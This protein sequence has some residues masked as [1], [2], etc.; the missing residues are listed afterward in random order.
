[1]AA[2]GFYRYQ[3]REEVGRVFGFFE[4][5]ATGG[6]T[7]TIVDTSLTR[8]ADDYFIG[9]SVYILYAGG[10]TPALEESYCTDFVSST[11]TITV[12][13]AFTAAV[14]SGDTYQLY[15]NV[16]VDEINYCLNAV[17][18]D[19]EIETQLTPSASTLDYYVSGAKDLYRRQQ[20]I[21]VWVRP[22]A[23]SLIMPYELTGWKFFDNEGELYVRIPY[24][25]SSTDQLWLHY[26]GGDL[27][28][29]DCVITN[30][31]LRLIR[32]RATVYL[33]ENLIAHQNQGGMDRWGTLLRYWHEELR[34][35]EARHQRVH[36][37]VR[38]FNWSGG[39]PEAPSYDTVGDARLNIDSLYGDL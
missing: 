3:L 32:A 15:K 14:E 39:F 35:E 28:R 21:G 2:V 13:P 22:S 37:K 33:I 18:K 34:L 23:D 4:G 29:D 31:P 1:M 17:C 5:T 24:A 16:T 11:G 10:A 6:S 36:R 20:M 27:T 19:A 30:L 25:L 9:Q 8:F 38:K 7:T 26:Y 12:S